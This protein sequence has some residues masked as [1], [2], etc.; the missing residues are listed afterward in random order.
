[1]KKALCLSAILL[2]FFKPAAKALT[3]CDLAGNTLAPWN[4]QAEYKEKYFEYNMFYYDAAITPGIM[5]RGM[6]QNFVLR[7]GLPDGFFASLDA[8]YLFQNLEAASDASGAEV[9][10][11]FDYNNVQ[12]L[13]LLAGKHQEA[14]PGILLGIRYPFDNEMADN[15][16]L[17]DR[18]YMYN[19]VA[20]IFQKGSLGILRYSLQAVVEEPVFI[21]DYL[22]SMDLSASLGFNFY[23]VPEKQV[24]DIIAEI[25]YYLI[26]RESK[27]SYMLTIMPEAVI[28]FYNDFN[29]VLGV[30][31]LVDADNWTL[32]KSEKL[33]YV[34][35]VNYVL[36]SP[37]KAAEAA[38]LKAKA[39]AAPGYQLNATSAAETGLPV[40][41]TR[42][43][44]ASMP[45][46]MTLTP[47]SNANAEPPPQ[48]IESEKNEK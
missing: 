44:D 17:I 43:S 27:N 48:P 38:A 45:L 10:P 16:R 26:Q 24:I 8:N 5:L 47:E 1:M 46:N 11:M 39:S 4:V 7:L 31:I 33:L 6:D 42:T 20:G 2:L 19:F 14:G 13:T 40:K 15:T 12:T 22:G 25:Q 3:Y 32:N 35:K 28:Q 37:R 29:F 30:E 23:D 34:V 36:N 21:S 41:I 9:S 18:K